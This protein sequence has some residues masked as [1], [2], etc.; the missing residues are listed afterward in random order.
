MKFY[1]IYKNTR[2]PKTPSFRALFPVK[3]TM[4]APASTTASKATTSVALVALNQNLKGKEIFSVESDGA[5]KQSARATR[6]TL[7]CVL[8][9]CS[10]FPKLFGNLGVVALPQM[11]KSDHS[12]FSRALELVN[13]LI[14][15]FVELFNTASPEDQRPQSIKALKRVSTKEW[16]KT[17]TDCT[18]SIS[19]G[20]GSGSSAGAGVG[21]SAVS[22]TV[23]ETENIPE[24]L[25]NLAS[26][27]FSPVDSAT[28]ASDEIAVNSLSEDSEW[29]LA[30]GNDIAGPIEGFLGDS[31]DLVVALLNVDAAVQ[32][33]SA[34]R[35]SLPRV[36]VLSGRV[37]R[38]ACYPL[39]TSVEYRRAIRDARI[40]AECLPS[41]P[42]NNIL[43]DLLKAQET[44][45][46]S[47]VDFHARGLNDMIARYSQ[48]HIR[49]AVNRNIVST[50]KTIKD[51]LK[52][53]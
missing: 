16:V 7:I 50:A 39:S 15:R 12:L 28:A 1:I 25:E 6:S 32:T 49:K 45:A 36:F 2:V 52:S 11:E 34:L 9:N 46:N 37:A 42:E 30:S 21:S 40:R 18:V 41:T 14:V 44:K 24:L 38:T 20:A 47:D 26:E 48:N 43:R 51:V 4:S 10:R 3:P 22:M 13:K 53:D 31:Y 23:L 33:D 19:G 29:T 5:L 35:D 27:V 17:V 8:A